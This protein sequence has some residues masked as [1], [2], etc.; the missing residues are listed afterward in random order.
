MTNREGEKTERSPAEIARDRTKQLGTEGNI[1][2]Q[3]GEILRDEGFKIE[4]AISAFILEGY[5]AATEDFLL[6]EDLLHVSNSPMEAG[7][8][9]II[10]SQNPRALPSVIWPKPEKR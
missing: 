5:V 1:G 9:V 8:A 7:I 3:I 10:A 6:D 4:D 2:R